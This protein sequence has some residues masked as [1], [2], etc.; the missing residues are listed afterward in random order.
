MELIRELLPVVDDFDRA[1]KVESPDKN[2]VKGIE[3]IYQRLLE[4]LKKMGLEP[5]E[6]EGKIFDP[7]MHQAIERLESEEYADGTVVS[8]FQDGYLFH[9]R[10]LRPAIVRVA[11]HPGQNENPGS[12]EN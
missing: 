1:L 12:V 9:G 8:V 3:I 7:H 4:M 2:Y 10:V 6:T 11:V 5:I